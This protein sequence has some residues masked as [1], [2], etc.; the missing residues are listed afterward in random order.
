MAEAL[1]HRVAGSKYS[2][3]QLTE[4]QKQLFIPVASRHEKQ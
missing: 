2:P 3:A 1:G 4:E